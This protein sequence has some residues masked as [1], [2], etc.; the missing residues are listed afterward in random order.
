MKNAF[1]VFKK[2]LKDTLKN[3]VILIQFVMLP[4]MVVVMNNAIQMEDMPENF[5]VHLF[6]TM[7]IG[8]APLTSI[9]AVISEEKEQN[10][11]RVLM[12]SN[13]KPVEYLLGVGGHIWLICMLG[14]LVF[15]VEGEYTGRAGVVFLTIMA[16]GILTSLLIGAVIGTWSKNQMMATSVSIPVMMV[17]SFLPMLSMFNSMFAKVARFTYSEQLSHMM[18]EVHNFQPD[19]ANIVIILINMGIALCLFVLAYKKRMGFLH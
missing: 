17:F 15:C 4:T 7:F 9:A 12:M 6:A 19:V 2:Q 13:V 10:T 8:M 11:L 1:A 5:F 14:A 16:V 3:K 18:G